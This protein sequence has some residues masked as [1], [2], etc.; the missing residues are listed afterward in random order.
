MSRPLLGLVT[1]APTAFDP[2]KFYPSRPRPYTLLGHVL[3]PPKVTPLYP[4]RSRP[5]TLLGHV[6]VPS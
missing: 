5:C 2:A 1:R 6:P 4:P 3:L